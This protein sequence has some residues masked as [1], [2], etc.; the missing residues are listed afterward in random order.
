[1]WMTN[2]ADPLDCFIDARRPHRPVCWSRP[3]PIGFDNILRCDK[4]A[5]RSWK[6]RRRGAQRGIRVG[7]SR[8]ERP[9]AI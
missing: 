2:N 8:D 3:S 7:D 9:Q 1:M 6:S 4:P 5:K